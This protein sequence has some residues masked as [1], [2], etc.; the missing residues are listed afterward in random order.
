[1]FLL[2]MMYG[3][4]QGVKEN[5]QIAIQWLKKAAQK[6]QQD[7]QKFLKENGIKY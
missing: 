2:G 4:G 6:G 7:A 5:E 1:M 3:A